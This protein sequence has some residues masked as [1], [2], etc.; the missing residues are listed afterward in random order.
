MPMRLGN[1]RRARALRGTGRAAMLRIAAT[2]AIV[3]SVAGYRADLLVPDASAADT[4]ADT[5]VRS[6]ERAASVFDGANLDEGK[7]LIEQHECE[8]CHARNVGGDGSAIYRPKGR[9]NSPSFLRGMVEYCN[10]QLGLQL[11]PEEVTSIG[12]VL[13]REHYRFD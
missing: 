6:G 11:F 12:A 9:I 8:A 3:G 4:A 5:A 2:I 1:R 7:A 10:T 13:N